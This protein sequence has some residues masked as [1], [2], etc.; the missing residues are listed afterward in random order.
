[1]CE[2]RPLLDREKKEV[3]GAALVAVFTLETHDESH[4]DQDLV[5]QVTRSTLATLKKCIEETE[6]KLD[7]VEK[8]FKIKLF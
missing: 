1:M 4:D 2:L 5:F 6:K 7:V 3:E 8:A